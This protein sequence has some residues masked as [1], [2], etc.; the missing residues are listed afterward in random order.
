MAQFEKL[1]HHELLVVR[2]LL[3]KQNKILWGSLMN[4]DHLIYL[5][6]SIS[7]L[8]SLEI[9]RVFNDR[10]PNIL[11]IHYFSLFLYDKDRNQLSLSSHNRPGLDEDLLLI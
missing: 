4:L 9:S 10:L 2:N 5:Q 6:K 11:G 8:S 1:K 3:K 7:L